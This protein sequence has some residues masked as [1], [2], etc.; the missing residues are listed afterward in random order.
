MIKVAAAIIERKSLILAARR[1]PGLHLAGYWEFPGGKVEHGESPEECLARELKEELHITAKIGDYVGDST[2]DYGGKII[3]L[4][5][6]RVEHISG[7]FVLHDHDEMRWLAL[8]DLKNLN[9]APADIPLVELYLAS[10]ST[11]NYYEDNAIAYCNQTRQFDVMEL[12]PPFLNMLPKDA[13]ILDLGCGSGRDSKVFIEKGYSVTALDSSPQVAAYAASIIDQMVVVSSFQELDYSNEFDGVWASASLLHCPRKQMLT[14]LN[15]IENAIKPLGVVYMS[16]KWGDDEF[17][18]EK[19]RYFNNYTD[20]S[21]QEIIQQVPTF[22]LIKLWSTTKWLRDRD[23]KWV[24][25]LVKKVV[26]QS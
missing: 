12:Y 8:E 21:L 19:G 10:A 5:A 17:M 11:T 7:E 18:D 15:R 25:V 3:R 13:K 9:W 14:V 1:K 20:I 2:Y 23:Q 26:E 22:E 24:N 16:F 4:L 6:Y